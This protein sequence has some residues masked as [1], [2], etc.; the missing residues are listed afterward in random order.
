M[1]PAARRFSVLFLCLLSL[2]TAMR[3]QVAFRQVTTPLEYDYGEGIVL[4]QTSH[5]T[6]LHVAYRNI[7]TPPYV[8]FHYPPVY[9]L[10][11]RLTDRFVGNPLVSGRLTSVLCTLGVLLLIGS[12]VYRVI[13][14]RWGRGDRFIFAAIAFCLP[15]QLEAMTWAGFMRVDMAALLFSYAG[16]VIFILGGERLLPQV[17]SVVLFVVALYTRQTTIAAALACLAAAAIVSLRRAAALSLFGAALTVSLGAAGNAL[18]SGGFVTNL[19]GYNVN[20]F[21]MMRAAR[22][23]AQC[24]YSLGLVLPLA[25]VIVWFQIAKFCRF[26]LRDSLI[27]LRANLAHVSMR[28][29]LVVL[30]IHFA[31]TLVTVGAYGKL[32][33]NCNYFLD[34]QICAC[35]LAAFLLF[36]LYARP[37]SSARLLSRSYGLAP[38]IAISFGLAL[39]ALLLAVRTELVFRGMETQARIGHAQRVV[40]EIRAAGGPVW[41]DNMTLLAQAGR[42]VVAEPAIVSVLA[43]SGRW[44]ES[45]LIRM[46]RE[47]RLALIVAHMD[48]DSDDF[49]S[50]G[51][52]QAIRESYGLDKRIG[53]YS[54][55]RPRAR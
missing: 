41:S 46:L 11:V 42:D 21:S 44:N 32:G 7:D 14:A 47:R 8:V 2:A 51:V 37:E 39:G 27:R 38:T 34:F 20:P 48:L 45:G 19:I 33:S 3:L 12:L 53:E 22:G 36:T 52:R 26:R 25:L 4:F 6:D 28:R 18:T 17:V 10:L 1:T 30:S 54:L 24:F 35:V 16:L 50:P 49:Y 15:L 23:F 13:P 40:G 55:Y 43:R 31:L 29:A 9:Y 5:I